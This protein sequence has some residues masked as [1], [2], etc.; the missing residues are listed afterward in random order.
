LTRFKW[1]KHINVKISRFISEIG[2]EHLDG[3]KIY[4]AQENKNM[5]MLDNSSKCISVDDDY[6]SA[7]AGYFENIPSKKS[8]GGSSNISFACLDSSILNDEKWLNFV[9]STVIDGR[10]YEPFTL[11]E[12]GLTAED[13]L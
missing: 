5:N 9:D 13:F 3:T 4:N 7:Q 10:T 12:N 11:L 2:Y 8:Y 1:G 6:D